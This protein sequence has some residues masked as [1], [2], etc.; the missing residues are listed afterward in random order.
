[1]TSAMN[2][3]RVSIIVE[4][5]TMAMSMTTGGHFRLASMIPTNGRSDGIPIRDFRFRNLHA[6]AVNFY[7]GSKDA[8]MEHCHIR[9]IGDD[10]LAAWAHDWDDRPN[11]AVIPM[12]LVRGLSKSRQTRGQ[13]TTSA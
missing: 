4:R 9:N 2:L 13:S 5:P 8:T 11:R 1:M 3:H 10:A 6:D 12:V 7:G